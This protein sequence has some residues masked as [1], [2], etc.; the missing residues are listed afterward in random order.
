M[1]TEQDQM[2]VNGRERTRVTETATVR[3]P[4]DGAAYRRVA[5]SGGVPKAHEAPVVGRD[6]V[7]WGPSGLVR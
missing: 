4:A 3:H 1:A 2:Q 6:R 5:D 7:R